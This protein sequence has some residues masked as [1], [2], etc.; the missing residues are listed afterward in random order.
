MM[1]MLWSMAVPRR[2]HRR[3][4]S[5]SLS[6]EMTCSTRAL[7]GRLHSAVV[8]ADDA[9][10]IVASRRGDRSGGL[11]GVIW[12]A[13]SGQRADGADLTNCEDRERHRVWYRCGCRWLSVGDGFMIH[14]AAALTNT[15]TATSAEVLPRHRG[16][17]KAP[18][19]KYDGPISVIRLELHLGDDR[20]RQR[21]ERQWAAGHQHQQT[22]LDRP[23][24][25]ATTQWPLLSKQHS[26]YLRTDQAR[27]DVADP[28]ENNQPPS[29]L[30]LHDPLRVNS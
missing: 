26:A 30:V 16:K 18:N 3:N 6:P 20:T 1:W 22:M 14:M 2:R 10:G 15:A 17:S 23:G 5:Q 28:A 21:L 7:I 24:P 8:V 11:S 29:C 25:A 9:A 4:I 12:Y 13:A 27:L 19:F